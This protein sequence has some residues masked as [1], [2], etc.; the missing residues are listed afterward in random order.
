MLHLVLLI[1]TILLLLMRYDG[2]V[3]LEVFTNTV[4]DSLLPDLVVIC[5]F[6]F[7]HVF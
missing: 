4:V 1:F 7:Y 6:H 5:R 3:W 2:F